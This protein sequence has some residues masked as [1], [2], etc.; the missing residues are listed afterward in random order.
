MKKTSAPRRIAVV[1]FGGNALIR[2]QEKGTLDEQLRNASK[3]ASVLMK[4]VRSGYELML[5]HGNGPQ[6]GISLIRVHSAAEK[7]PV[8]PLDV[9]VSETQGSMGYLLET[10]L[11]NRMQKEGL[12]KPVVTVLTRVVVD[13]DDPAFNEPTKPIGPFFK[14]DK[15]KAMMAAEDVRM[16]EDSGRGWRRVVPSPKPLRIVEI[17][18]L[19]RL[20]ADGHVVIAGGGGGI[21]VREDED[22]ILAGVEAVID[23]DYVAALIAKSVGAQL[24]VILTEVSNVCVD[25]GKKTQRQLDRMT[26]LEAI[27]YFREGQ[28]PKGSMGPK[29]EACIDYL[30]NGGNEALITNAA[31][32]GEAL[33]RKSGTYIVRSESRGFIDLR[34]RQS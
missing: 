20:A 7:V 26:L 22:G 16:V 12:V 4:I 29:I 30:M 18:T 13:A 15:A 24:F 6:V 11:S 19:R 8:V 25:F 10:A 9:C 34:P 1:A 14:E 23:K 33:E 2:S 21:P 17:D 3:A 31:S 28:F 5:V 32:L 27:D